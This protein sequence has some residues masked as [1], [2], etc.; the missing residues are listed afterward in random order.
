MT[1]DVTYGHT[2]SLPTDDP[3]AV[4]AWPPVG[5][6]HSALCFQPTTSHVAS[7]GLRGRSAGKRSEGCSRELSEAKMA[8]RWTISMPFS[9]RCSSGLLTHCFYRRRRCRAGGQRQA[10]ERRAEPLSWPRRRRSGAA[11]CRR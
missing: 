9:T 8:W 5:S 11:P 10:G 1:Y 6:T 2:T 7:R 4:R 3:C